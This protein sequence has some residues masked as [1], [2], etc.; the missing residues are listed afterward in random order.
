LA[1]ILPIE[2]RHAV[3]LGQAIGIE[4]RDLAPVIENMSNAATPQKFPIEKG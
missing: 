1:S 4:I 2:A 3:V